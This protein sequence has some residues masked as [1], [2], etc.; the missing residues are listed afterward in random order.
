MPLLIIDA[1]LLHYSPARLLRR[2]LGFDTKEKSTPLFILALFFDI[3]SWL[4]VLIL[5]SLLFHTVH[6]AV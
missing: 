6:H 3:A 2:A 4:V 5:V 1:V